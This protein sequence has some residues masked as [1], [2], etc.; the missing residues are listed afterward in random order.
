M[1]AFGG[2][3]GVEEEDDDDDDDEFDDEDSAQGIRQYINEH[4]IIH[5]SIMG[6]PQQSEHEQTLPVLEL[7]EDDD[8]LE[9]SEEEE[10]EEDDDV[11]EE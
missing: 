9:E 11:D 5:S 2:C 1:P 4:S 10:D 7:E 6:L 3:S 8:K